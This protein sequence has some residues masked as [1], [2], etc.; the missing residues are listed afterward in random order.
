M[1]TGKEIEAV[2]AGVAV[3]A[4]STPTEIMSAEI[5]PP[6]AWTAVLGPF[7]ALVLVS[8]VGRAIIMKDSR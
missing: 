3:E 1:A 6:P 4:V 2:S 7:L 5:M 8:E